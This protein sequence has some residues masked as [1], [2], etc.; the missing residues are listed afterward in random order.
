[1]KIYLNKSGTA[2]P[3]LFLLAVPTALYLDVQFEYGMHFLVTVVSFC[4][5]QAITPH[6]F[7]NGNFILETSLIGEFK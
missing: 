2:M 1:M 5:K 7:L 6:C 3:K 4:K